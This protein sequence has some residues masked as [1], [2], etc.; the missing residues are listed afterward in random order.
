M[1][2]NEPLK[3]TLD[4][5]ADEIPAADPS[6]A[7]A[8]TTTSR[9]RAQA[10]EAGRQ[11]AGSVK[12][13]ADKLTRKVADSAAEVTSRSADAARE[14]MGEVIQAQSKATADAIEARLREVDWKQEAQKG[15][16]GGLRWLS[17]RLDDLAGK[18]S[19]PPSGDDGPKADAPSDS[20]K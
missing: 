8:G 2:D 17:R 10:E 14:K 1:P 6:P 20:D 7:Q 4:D 12:G 16:E 3:I 19:D 9:V 5:L 13:T 18:V 11:V 15:A